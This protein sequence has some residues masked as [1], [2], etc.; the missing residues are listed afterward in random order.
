MK[1]SDTST[2]NT[3]NLSAI[4]SR[5]APNL[6]GFFCLRAYLPSR[7]SDNAPK[8]NNITANDKSISELKQSKKATNIAKINL[9]EVIIVGKFFIILN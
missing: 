1:V 7:A 6:E 4:G 3:K 5:N 9:L 8:T 2:K